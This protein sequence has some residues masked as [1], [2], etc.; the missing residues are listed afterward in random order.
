MM[1]EIPE[2]RPQDVLSQAQQ[3]AN[4]YNNTITDF[5]RVFC[6]ADDLDCQGG[7]QDIQTVLNGMNNPAETASKGMSGDMTPNEANQIIGQTLDGAMNA[8]VGSFSGWTDMI[9]SPEV[10][11]LFRTAA[12]DT[13]SANP[14]ANTNGLD[15]LFN[16]NST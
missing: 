13:K 14:E 15:I 11:D 1:L 2:F 5:F 10:K 16:T 6:P 12:N 9:F 7:A 8:T 3:T 4:A